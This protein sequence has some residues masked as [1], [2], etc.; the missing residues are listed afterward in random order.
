[1]EVPQMGAWW[2]ILWAVS[3]G[4][5][6]ALFLW[7][8]RLNL[9]PH[10]REDLG[11]HGA[12]A[13]LSAGPV[14]VSAFVNAVLRRPLAYHVTPKGNASRPDRP[15]TFRLH[16]TWVVVMGTALAASFLVGGALV[17]SCWAFVTFSAAALPPGMHAL[18][19]LRRQSPPVATSKPSTVRSP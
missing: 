10:E 11:V 17:P 3:W 19:G 8:R 18:L 16:V 7:L 6:L 12:M 15:A 5:T 9:A 14:Y 13:T 1:V 4:T 2:P